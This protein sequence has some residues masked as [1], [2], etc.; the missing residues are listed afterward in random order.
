MARWPETRSEDS[1]SLWKPL[2]SVGCGRDKS[3]LRLRRLDLNLSI[4]ASS[5]SNWGNDLGQEIL[6]NLNK[7]CWRRALQ[8]MDQD[9]GV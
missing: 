8:K 3:A 9:V 7:T 4:E 1:G 6:F 5:E 2:H